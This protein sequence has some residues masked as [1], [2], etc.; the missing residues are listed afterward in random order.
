VRGLA[1][2][3]PPE[4]ALESLLGAPR[5]AILRALVCPTSIGRLAETLRSVPSAATHH[6][7]ALEAAG[8][9]TRDRSGRNVLV[10]RTERGEALLALYEE[11]DTPF[12]GSSKGLSGRAIRG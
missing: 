6:V 1:T 7:G 12:R 11:L 8:L 10:R 3:E 9:V 4:A 2:A 5:A